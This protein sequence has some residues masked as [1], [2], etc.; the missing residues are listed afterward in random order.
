[1]FPSPQQHDKHD[2]SEYLPRPPVPGAPAKRHTGCAQPT[3]ARHTPRVPITSSDRLFPVLRPSGTLD[4]RSKQLHDKHDGSEYLLRLPVPGTPTNGTLDAHSKQLHDTHDS[5]DYL[6]RPP[7]PGAPAKRHTGC[8]QQTTARQTRR[9]RNT[10]RNDFQ[11]RRENASRNGII[12]DCTLPT[13]YCPAGGPSLPHDSAAGTLRL[14]AVQER[15]EGCGNLAV[16]LV[17]IGRAFRT[18]AP[19]LIPA[20]R[21]ARTCRG[22]C[23]R[24]RNRR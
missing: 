7:V 3:T 1:M 18:T 8:A 15:D 22:R 6:L 2:G 17:S 19:Y 16:P 11:F 14:P 13:G 20:C 23:R 24:N 9:F 5:S 10:G 21:S 4:A 12:S